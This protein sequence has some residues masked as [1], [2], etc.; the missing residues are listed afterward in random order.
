MNP[1]F[2]CRL[3]DSVRMVGNSDVTCGLID[4]KS[5]TSTDNVAYQG[6]RRVFAGTPAPRRRVGSESFG[7][8]AAE[9]PRRVSPL[10]RIQRMGGPAMRREFHFFWI[11]NEKG[12]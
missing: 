9:L 7:V 5:Q 10:G 12:T 3:H 4:Y 6:V 8:D 11:T 1:V 2:F